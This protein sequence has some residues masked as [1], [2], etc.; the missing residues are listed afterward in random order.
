MR[1][2]Q[3]P[4]G[5]SLKVAAIKQP[6]QCLLHNNTGQ[7]L[8][9]ERRSLKGRKGRKRWGTRRRGRVQQREV[10]EES[11]GKGKEEKGHLFSRISQ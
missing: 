2:L 5:P 10:G 8:W 11:T 7:D 3:G 1:Q 9:K 6:I 4:L